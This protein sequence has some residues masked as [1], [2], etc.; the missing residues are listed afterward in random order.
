MLS[1]YYM[2]IY[3]VAIMSQAKAGEI[4]EISGMM[5]G[6]QSLMMVFGPLLA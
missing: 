1:G 4:G 6:V 2:P 5:G 3:N